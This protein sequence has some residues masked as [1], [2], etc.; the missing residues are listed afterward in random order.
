MIPHQRPAAVRC[1]STPL[2]TL[3]ALVVIAAGPV[4]GIAPAA[5]TE[6]SQTSTALQRPDPGRLKQVKLLAVGNSFSGNA[7]KYLKDIVAASGNQ[8][9]F[10]HASIGGCPLEKHW[11]LA[12]AFEVDPD[13]AGNRP[14]AGLK[15]GTKASLKELLTAEKWDV[16]TFQQA[17]IKSFDPETYQPY[18]SQLAAY[19][20]K[21]APTAR[22]YIH[23]T[24]AYRADDPL[25][26]K[27]IT[28]EQMYERLK[29]AYARTA[30][31]IDALVLPVGDAFE[32]ARRNPA[33]A[34]KFPDPA[35][36]YKNPVFPNL[37]DQTHSLHTG[38][39]WV[40]PKTGGKPT[41]K[42][43]G[44]HANA[45]GQY[46]GAA[47]WFECLYGQSIVGNTFVPAGM[48]A[49]DVA[50]LQ[51]IAHETVAQPACVPAKAPA[52]K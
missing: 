37:P 49:E 18:A 47:V 26:K 33:W 32:R 1:R 40:K 23:Q 34:G 4:F 15:P 46:L 39:S 21:H 3:L 38:Y 44:H 20:R 41:L 51:K 7:T 17:S 5:A 10:G 24:W 19:A 13:S 48:K 16:I 43:D 25:F 2:W 28:Q 30:G 36:D 45:A 12:E 27:D 14:Y 50:I 9:T 42:L 6:P 29:A 11:K 35:Y 8:L 52:T 31:E 22:L